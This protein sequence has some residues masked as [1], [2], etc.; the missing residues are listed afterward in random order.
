MVNQQ[1]ISVRYGLIV[2]GLLTLFMWLSAFLWNDR[3]DI[4]IAQLVGYFTMILSFTFLYRGVKKYRESKNE[5]EFTLKEAFKIGLTIA[6]I[7]SLCYVISWMIYYQFFGQDY[8]SNYQESLLLKMKENG[9]NDLQIG[10][11]Q[12]QMEMIGEK[13]KNPFYRFGI[14]FIEVLPMGIIFSFFSALILKRG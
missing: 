7:A 2:G 10:E 1:N 12:L 11:Q 4:S 6:L 5:T 13:Y 14:T 8:M 3:M 9:M